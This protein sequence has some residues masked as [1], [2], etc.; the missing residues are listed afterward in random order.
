ML[1]SEKMF[2]KSPTRLTIDIK[3]YLGLWY[4]IA[5]LPV[6]YE[7]NF[8]TNITAEYSLNKDGTIQVKNSEFLN[9]RKIVIFGKGYNTDDT[10]T[11]LKIDFNMGF[12]GDY[13]IVKIA[14]DYSYSIVSSSNKN[15]LWI[16]S[17]TKNMPDELYNKL[18][19]W[20]EIN[21]YNLDKLIKN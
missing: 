14:D 17:R 19:D 4:E 8:A 9:G 3:K 21:N 20:L 18:I 1:L 13:W 11:K 16:L 5:R 15:A 10:F 12:L 2:F 7:S 6:P